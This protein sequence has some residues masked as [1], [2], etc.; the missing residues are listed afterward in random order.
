MRFPSFDA[1][2]DDK[3]DC[4]TVKGE[5]APGDAY[6][7]PKVIRVNL[8]GGPGPMVPD[9]DGGGHNGLLDYHGR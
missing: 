4:M 9:R 6:D 8:F 1:N 3:V 5:E 2:P 7:P